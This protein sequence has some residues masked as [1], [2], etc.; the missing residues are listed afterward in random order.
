MK[1]T[2]TQLEKLIREEMQDLDERDL[3]QVFQQR[4]QAKAAQAS[5]AAPKPQKSPAR[6]VAAM[7]MLKQYQ[8]ELADYSKP[9]A[10]VSPAEVF[11]LKQKIAKLKQMM[12]KQGAQQESKTEITKPQLERIIKEEL[13]RKE[14]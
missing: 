14:T 5:G 4:Q 2:R 10:N 8:D 6:S 1:I 3:A 11:K 13:S 12:Q 7:R 9:G